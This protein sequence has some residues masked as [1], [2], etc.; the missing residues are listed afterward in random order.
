MNIKTHYL[1][2]NKTSGI[3]YL[4][5]DI[6]PDLRQHFGIKT[7]KRSLRTHNKFQ[8]SI[9]CL[10]LATHYKTTFA[11]LRGMPKINLNN[12]TKLITVKSDG[13]E[14]E[15]DTGDSELD[16]QYAEKWMEKH[17][18]SQK[19]SSSTTKL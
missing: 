16:Y 4:R 11:T 15:F 9:I 1:T 19:S 17:G 10:R 3:Y 7:I 6:P 12:L 14:I 13:N 5:L 2:R 18:H 8:A